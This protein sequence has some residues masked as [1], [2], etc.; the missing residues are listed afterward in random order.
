MALVRK[1]IRMAQLIPYGSDPFLTLRREMDQ[2]FDNMLRGFGTPLSGEAGAMQ[3]G[4]MRSI[5]PRMDVCETDQDLCITA[6]LPGV[7]PSDVSVTLN[8][9]VLT[10][11]GE[12]RAERRDEGQNYHVMERSSSSFQRSLRLPYPVDPAQVQANFENGVLKVTC[13]KS[14]AQRRAQRIEVR[15]SGTGGALP[16]GGTAQQGGTS[17]QADQEDAERSRPH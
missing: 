5:A 4:G 7:A 10:I 14:A 6:D 9:D 12:K 11:R 16:G 3:E 8:D 15:S 1:E 13:P 2:L 17:G